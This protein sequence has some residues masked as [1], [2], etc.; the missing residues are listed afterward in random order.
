MIKDIQSYTDN[1]VRKNLALLEIHL[2]QASFSDK[3]FCEEC[4]NKHILV[5]EGFAEEGLTAC[6]DCDEKKFTTLLNF[7]NS[8]KEMDFQKQGIE[9]AKQ[10]RILRKNFVPCNGE[11]LGMKDRDDIKKK[12]EELEL[13]KDLA[14]DN[15]TKDRL[16]YG[17]YLLNWMNRGRRCSDG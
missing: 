5:L 4:I 11:N 12:I 9:I 6:I 17:I 16:E 1:E 7:L 14:Q 3:D 10:I 2:K 13:E 15:V 8:I